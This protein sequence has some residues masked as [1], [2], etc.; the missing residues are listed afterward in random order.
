MNNEK[1]N[2]QVNSFST[3]RQRNKCYPHNI[4]KWFKTSHQDITM[5]HETHAILTDHDQWT[6]EWDGKIFYSDGES[7][8]RGLGNPNP[9][10]PF[11]II[12][13]DR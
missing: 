4:F 9:Q 8:S 11:G 6:N 2:I 7:N 5:I 10:K 1:Q 13:I 3:R 12:R